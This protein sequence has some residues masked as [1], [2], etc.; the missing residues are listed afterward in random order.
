MP[1]LIR[2]GASGGLSPELTTLILPAGRICWKSLGKA[3]Q[4]VQLTSCCANS[5]GPAPSC[6]RLRMRPFP[7][8]SPLQHYGN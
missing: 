1:C 5:V 2:C 4:P 8:G 6:Q 7:A 3:L